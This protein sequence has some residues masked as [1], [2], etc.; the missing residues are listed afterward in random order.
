MG[1]THGDRVTGRAGRSRGG[2]KSGTGH[3]GRSAGASGS[4]RTD[5]PTGWSRWSRWT[6]RL[7]EEDRGGGEQREAVTSNMYFLST[8][9][10]DR[11][12]VQVI[13]RGQRHKRTRMCTGSQG[14]VTS[15]AVG[16]I[17]SGVFLRTKG[18]KPC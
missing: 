5:S 11:L 2:R 15:R 9:F 10:E 7:Q 13:E 14:E 17:Q 3:A 16:G 18:H 6:G 12:S 8:R 4:R 1:G